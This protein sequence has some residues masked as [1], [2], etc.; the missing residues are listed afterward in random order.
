MK[1]VNAVVDR[2]EESIFSVITQLAIKEQ[3][4]NL[5]QG[6][7]DF[8]GPE[9][10]KEMVTSALYRGKNQ[11]APSYGVLALREAIAN[12][13]ES[14][15]SL[16]YDPKSEILVTNGATEA[17]YSTI[18]ALV[19]PGDEVVVLEP[20]YDSYM[21]SLQMAG[22]VIK[23]ATLKAPHFHY[24][25]E[26]LKA[27]MNEKTK[28]L[29]LNNPHNPTGRVFTRHEL[30][31]IAA[32][33]MKSDCYV[34][35]DEVYE[36][37]T[38]ERP[39]IPVATLEGMRDRVVTISSVGK[40][41]SLTGWKIGW[42]CGPRTLIKAIHNAHQFISFCVAHPLQE[43]IA[44]ALP[45][46]DRYVPEFRAEYRARRDLLVSGLKTAGFEVSEPEGTYFAIA[47]VPPG[48]NDIDFSKTL[49]LSKKVATIPTSIFYV[50]SDEGRGLVR[51]C[52]AKREETLKAALRNLGD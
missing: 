13:Y 2:F 34:L 26:E 41:L 7:P 35:S 17:I 52:F 46:M 32:L 12:Q 42:A 6:F 44:E 25:V 3:A 14:F 8:D 47:K 33:V 16:R 23:V 19:N 31:E 4:I 30:S 38:F 10:V 29:I 27:Q 28:L 20:V 39:H 21:A 51:F 15:Y 37:L 45:R 43:A 5:A 50:R 24:D 18:T 36:F 40:T 1:P 22:A 9:W 48:Q 11:Y 49:I